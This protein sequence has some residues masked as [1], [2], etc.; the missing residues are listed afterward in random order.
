MDLAPIKGVDK[1]S[2]RKAGIEA[3]GCFS[4]REGDAAYAARFYRRI[5]KAD[6]FLSGAEREMIS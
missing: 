6:K 1:G 2:F 4:S 5:D 3:A